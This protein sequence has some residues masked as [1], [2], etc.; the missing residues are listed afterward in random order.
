MP[1]PTTAPTPKLENSGR[2]RQVIELVYCSNLNGLGANVCS[3]T[4]LHQLP[5]IRR[6]PQ[7]GVQPLF[8][9]ATSLLLI[10][11]NVRI[12]G[13]PLR[14]NLQSIDHLF[15]HVV[16]REFVEGHQPDE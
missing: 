3:R 2:D 5:P 4:L 7:L 11:D 6:A 10:F 8:E 9:G 14:V 13:V 1:L 16:R 15:A 12:P